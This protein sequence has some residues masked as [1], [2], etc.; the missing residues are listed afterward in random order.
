MACITLIIMQTGRRADKKGNVGE[1]LLNHF[2]PNNTDK[3]KKALFLARY[4][5]EVHGWL[6]ARLQ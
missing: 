6:S 4:D 1:C 2:E 3:L 5:T